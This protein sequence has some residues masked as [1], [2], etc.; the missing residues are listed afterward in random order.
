MGF[1]ILVVWLAFTAMYDVWEVRRQRRRRAV[2]ARSAPPPEQAIPSPPPA[3]PGYV[4]LMVTARLLS[5]QLDPALY[6][7]CMAAIA[8]T[9]DRVEDGRPEPPVAADHDAVDRLS[10]TLPELSPD[11][12]RAA[13]DLAQLGA[14]VED[15][16]R[17][18]EL[19]APQALRIIVLTTG[20]RH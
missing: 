10:A 1:A 14:G 8:S 17:L 7:D 4:E 16:V 12:V 18:L 15:L 13:V 11:T 3:E 9:V 5:G 20:A 2:R 6:R 19:T